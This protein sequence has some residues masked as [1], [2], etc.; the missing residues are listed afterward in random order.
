MEDLLASSELIWGLLVIAVTWGVIVVI[1]VL[2]REQRRG[3]PRRKTSP[4]GEWMSTL[5]LLWLLAGVA[6]WSWT[7]S[8]RSLEDLGFTWGNGYGVM[9]AWGM[10]AGFTGMILYQLWSVYAQEKT[11]EQMSKVLLGSGDYDQILPRRRADMWGFYALGVTAGITEEIVFRA[12]LISVLALVMPVWAA[13]VA[14]L[15]V[16]VT[17]HAYQ[18]PKGMLRIL[19]VSVV[20]TVVYVVSG[21]LWP[22]ILL[23][24]LTD[25]LS[26]MM[27][28][29]I[30]PREGYVELPELD[31]QAA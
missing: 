27:T 8:D 19:P 5:V 26:G 13:G 9:I 28:A 16:F 17:C 7:A 25:V 22:A 23:H 31:G 15:A 10:V 12:F 1:D 6:V 4:F 24:I 2:R 3:K 30:L 11:R 21:S 20:L 29:R 14:A 18:G